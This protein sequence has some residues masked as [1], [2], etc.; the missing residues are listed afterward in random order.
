[1]MRHLE[2]VLA[3][4]STPLIL[5]A[6]NHIHPIFREVC[7][8]PHLL[9]EG[10]NASPDGLAE[11]D[12]H[13]RAFEVVKPRLHAKMRAACKRYDLL[14]TT[15]RVAFHL[16]EILRAVDQH[17][18]EVLFAAHGA[19][20]WGTVD[21]GNAVE[22]RRD[23]KPGDVD[24]LDVA[25]NQTIANGGTAYVVDANDV[26]SRELVAAILRW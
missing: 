8:Y 25:V 17:R 11:S 20:V 15:D 12:L 1:V 7:R 5:V 10:V 18:V 19:H 6:V 14:K 24:L 13:H 2:P 21:A 23:R 26:P 3:Q 9:A 22:V 16:E 4:E